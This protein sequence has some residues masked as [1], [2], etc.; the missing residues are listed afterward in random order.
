GLELGEIGLRSVGAGQDNLAIDDASGTIDDAQDRLRRDALSAA[1]FADD[2]QRLSRGDVERSAVDGQG[3]SL[4]LEKTGPQIPDRKKRP[5]VVPHDQSTIRG[6]V[7][8]AGSCNGSWQSRK[9]IFPAEVGIGSIPNPVAHEIERE[10]R[11]DDG[12]GRKK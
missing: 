1:A 2:A 5:R 8:G 11:D 9:K 7:S 3:R 12:K 4:V 6:G 10:D